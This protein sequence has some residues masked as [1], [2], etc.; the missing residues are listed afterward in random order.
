MKKASIR[1]MLADDHMLM[2]MGL[3]TLIDCEDDMKIVG[4]AKNGRQAVELAHALKPDIIIMD[5]LMPELSGA[6][7]TKLIHD[8]YPEIKIMVL[9][10]FGTSKEMS[11]AIM[12]GADGALMKDTAADELIKTIRAIV[13][14]ERIIPDRLMRQAAEDNVTPKL[15]DRHLE[16]LSSI[17]Q[18]QS[19][20]DIA[21]QY[22]L[23]EI[24]IK[25]QVSKIF[26]RLG[27]SNRSEAV[28]LALRKQ[29]LK[30]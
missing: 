14:G 24:S 27:V 18:G 7:A 16:I 1:I 21:K 5:L 30:S 26:A 19:N 13:A 9:T 4:E 12:N 17:A 3:S 6:E 22:G 2:R 20:S 10:S 11:D 15:S 25:K 8:A 23:S 29:M 28:A